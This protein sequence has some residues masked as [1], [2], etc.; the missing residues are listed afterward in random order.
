M[1]GL[2]TQCIIWLSI[3]IDYG[4]ALNI[5]SVE[6]N[7]SEK[8]EYEGRMRYIY[9]KTKREQYGKIIETALGGTQWNELLKEA[10][11]LEG[12]LETQLRSAH[13]VNNKCKDNEG[14]HLHR[15]IRICI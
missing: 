12:I 3:G 2:L 7:T 8:F 5:K 14:L 10:S 6:I 11:A 9:N 1:L 15:R 4:R 13:V